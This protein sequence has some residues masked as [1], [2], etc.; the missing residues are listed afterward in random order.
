MIVLTM[1]IFYFKR[2]LNYFTFVHLVSLL[3]ETLI[4]DDGFPVQGSD[5][6]LVVGL[7]VCWGGRDAYYFSLQKEQTHS[8]KQ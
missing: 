6:I 5:D 4:R 8:G 1:N 3:Q 2:F 7:A